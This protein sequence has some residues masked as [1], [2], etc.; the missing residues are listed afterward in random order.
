MIITH[1]YSTIQIKLIFFISN[2]MYYYKF[3]LHIDAYILLS[4]IAIVFPIL[5]IYKPE[6]TLIYSKVKKKK[7]IF[8]QIQ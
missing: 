3:K 8:N 7:E 6:L 1:V 4:F 2:K 5:I